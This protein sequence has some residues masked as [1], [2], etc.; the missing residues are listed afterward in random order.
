MKHFKADSKWQ[1]S[2]FLQLGGSLGCHNF[3]IVKKRWTSKVT[4]KV[5][6]EGLNLTTHW[7]HVSPNLLYCAD[8]QREVT[9]SFG[10]VA[11]VLS[12]LGIATISL[13]LDWRRFF[14]K[15]STPIPTSFFFFKL[16]PGTDGSICISNEKHTC[17]LTLYSLPLELSQQQGP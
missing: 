13:F 16:L 5:P 3:S 9:S 7:T 8:T 11:P 4:V 1:C 2:S 12:V 14:F 15:T 17:A 10:N 6:K